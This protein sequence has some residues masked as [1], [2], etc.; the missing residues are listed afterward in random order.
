MTY[1]VA[2]RRAAQRALDSLPANRFRIV[3]E[4]VRSLQDDPRLLAHKLAD[5][6]LW[7]VRVGRYRLIC[8]VEYDARSVT[9]LALT[10]RGEE[11][12]SGRSV[13]R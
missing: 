6:G 12:A 7:R 1:E 10:S 4:A 5:S 2:V 9:I 11:N 8:S 13:R 3:A